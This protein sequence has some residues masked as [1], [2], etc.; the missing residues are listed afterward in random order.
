M[1]RL[2]IWLALI[3]GFVFLGSTVGSPSNVGQQVTYTATVIT[4][5]VS[6]WL[7]AHGPLLPPT[8]GTVSFAD[9]GHDTTTSTVRVSELTADIYATGHVVASDGQEKDQSIKIKMKEQ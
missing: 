7:F 6:W 3:G 5:A 8:S 2:L 1:I 9:G 4:P